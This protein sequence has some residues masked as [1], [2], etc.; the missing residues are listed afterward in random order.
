MNMNSPQNTNH[1]GNHLLYSGFDEAVARM[2][3]HT[4]RTSFY[5]VPTQQTLP[6]QFLLSLLAVAMTLVL[7]PRATAMSR[8]APQDSSQHFSVPAKDRMFPSTSSG[9][10]SIKKEAAQPSYSS[11]ILTSNVFEAQG[12]YTATTPSAPAALG[13]AAYLASSAFNTVSPTLEVE[14]T[15]GTVVHIQV[16]ITNTTDTAIEPMLFEGNKTP[17]LG[18]PP[19][20]AMPE[21]TQRML[22]PTQPTRVDKQIMR[23]L[24][25]APDKHTDFFVFL[26]EQPDLSGAYAIE[27]WGTRGWYVYQALQQHAQQSQK[28]LRR[29]LDEEA[30]AYTPLWIVN[31]LIVYGTEADVNALAAHEDVAVLQ[32]TYTVSLD[33]GTS[34]PLPDTPSMGLPLAG[35]GN[36]DPDRNGICWNIA[37]VGADR[38]WHDFGV[39]GEGITIAHIDSGV[40]Y[41]HPALRWQYRGYYDPWG[42][43]HR[44]NWYDPTQW[45][46]IPEDAGNHGTHTMGTIVGRGDGSAEQPSIG[47]AP[48]ATW[49]AA[50][51]CGSSLCKAQDLYLAAEWL[52]APTKPDG[53]DPRPDLRPHIINNS[54]AS[55]SGDDKSYAD[56]IKAWRAAG[57][58]PVFAAGNTSSNK[59]CGSI[60]SPADYSFVLG[61]GA[62]NSSDKLASF[63]RIG[64]TV[65]GR[66]KPDMTAPGASITSSYAGSGLSYGTL[67]GTSMAAPHVSGVVALLWSANP[68]LIGD[69]DST[70]AILINTARPITDASYNTL[71][72][73]TDCQAD[74]IPNN[75]YGYGIVDAYAAIQ[76]ARVDVPWLELPEEPSAI[77][78]G[79]SGTLTVTL[80]SGQVVQPGRYYARLLVGSDDLGESLLTIPITFTVGL[81]DTNARLR[82]RVVDATTNTPLVATVQV[83]DG[84]R[85]NVED[86]D[87]GRFDIR[88]PIEPAPE[89][90][91]YTTYPITTVYTNPYTYTPPIVPTVYT[92]YTL[93][94]D[95]LGYVRKT[96]V[97]SLSAGMEQTMIFTL[98]LD[99]AKVAVNTEPVSATLDFGESL[100]GVKTLRN[101]GTLPL[102]YAITLQTGP[103]GVWRSDEDEGVASEWVTLPVDRAPI[104][105]AD[106]ESSAPLSLGFAFP[107]ATGVFTQVQVVSNGILVFGEPT[108]TDGFIPWCPPIPETDYG[109][110]MPL[111]ADLNPEEGGTIRYGNVGEGFVVTYEKVP[112][113]DKPE[114]QFTF[115]VVLGDDGSI[116]FNYRDITPLPRD[117]SV[118]LQFSS[119]D[120]QT[121]GCGMSIP[122]TSGLTLDLRP[123]PDSTQWLDVAEWGVIDGNIDE[124]IIFGTLE[125]GGHVD[126]PFML[127][128]ASPQYEQPY[129]SFIV[130]ES[131]DLQQPVIQ[132]PL[133]IW[134]RRAPHEV[135]LPLVAR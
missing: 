9:N 49:I 21:P 44:Y 64:P 55:G 15:L 94:A 22:A 83:H 81:T 56:F 104:T 1:D 45:V 33:T 101:V 2:A 53:T 108:K 134:T 46:E 123:Q 127:N 14:T 89:T 125:P 88:L 98:T 57:I 128:W 17:P 7:I 131:N 26:R 19:Q 58:F 105:L 115:Q 32:A 47:M 60:A 77:A 84:P 48:G 122:I 96:Q 129:R 18:V 28:K 4:R 95:A 103:F 43:D 74:V 132:V 36:C 85:V 117:V 99:R 110:I 133:Q 78:P 106:D 31:A 38:V 11:P 40:K 24:A 73:F 71:S 51:G 27:D 61:V 34:G 70:Y 8:R 102:D 114:Q 109:A 6:W 20:A 69:Y 16:P 67:N 12:A 66:M 65:D 10:G 92:T 37:Q 5:C 23:D 82:G 39:S 86:D 25:A 120:V 112:L 54:W 52:L 76:M 93:S 59:T 63:S 107:Y 124:H 121:I 50:R 75:I 41:D 111:R 29:W 13:E 116:R 79:E 87:G 35:T 100:R 126:V 97:V 42:Y 130:I 3:R 113:F 62:T 118:G 68:D 90:P 91:P 119:E 72:A 135:Y 30:I 80:D